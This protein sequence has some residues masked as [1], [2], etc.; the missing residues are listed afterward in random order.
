MRGGG[1]GNEGRERR[2]FFF[3]SV[4]LMSRA[5]LQNLA[6]AKLLPFARIFL[7]NRHPMR[8]R[9]FL[10]SHSSPPEAM[11]YDAI[12]AA[13]TEKG[14]GAPK[15][16]RKRL[17]CCFPFLG[18]AERERHREL[19]RSRERERVDRGEFFFL[20]CSFSSASVLLVPL[21]LNFKIVVFIPLFV[22]KLQWTSSGYI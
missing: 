1:G 4:T 12:S 17:T 22:L 19:R 21:L 16:H 11:K 15:G 5:S 8:F 2:L 9:L 6:A 7:F 3:L 20:L 18:I 14:N 10:F 13:R